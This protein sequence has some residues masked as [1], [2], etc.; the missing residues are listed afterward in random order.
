MNAKETVMKVIEELCDTPDIRE[1]HTLTEDLGL[2][3]LNMVILLVSLEEA[4]GIVLDESD[5]NPY[6]L[7]TVKD[8]LNLAEKYGGK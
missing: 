3:S 8:V 4:L 2:D 1:E 5:M 7:N 6:D